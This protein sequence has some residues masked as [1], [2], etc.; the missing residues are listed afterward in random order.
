MP[1]TPS[2]QQARL[3]FAAWVA[4][5]AAWL[6]Q[7]LPGWRE[8]VDPQRLDM[9]CGI[10]LRADP[11]QCGCLAA[12]LDLL[13]SHGNLGS[14]GNFVLANA[15]ARAPEDLAEAE[16]IYLGDAAQQWAVE[17]GLD[18]PDPLGDDHGPWDALTAAWLQALCPAGGEPATAGPATATA[19]LASA[20]LTDQ[21]VVDGV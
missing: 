16:A 4:A 19:D 17:H 20:S 3:E 12:Q 7:H 8:R 13:A 15:G 2:H 11:N 5:G 1:T 21:E 6:D 10:Y 14:Y 9:S 18:L